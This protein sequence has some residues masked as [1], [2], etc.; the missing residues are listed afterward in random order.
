MYIFIFFVLYTKEK[1][2]REIYKKEEEG[3][4][5]RKNTVLYM[6][7]APGVVGRGTSKRKTREWYCMDQPSSTLRWNEKIITETDQ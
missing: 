7:N 1:R 4:A 6:N 3:G 2:M 5:R